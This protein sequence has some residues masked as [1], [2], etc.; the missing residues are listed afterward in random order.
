M[1]LI[2]TW[3]NY[4]FAVLFAEWCTDKNT[5]KPGVDIFFRLDGIHSHVKSLK[6]IDS[7]LLKYILST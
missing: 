3:C 2:A 1:S 6:S 5:K 7:L 4:E